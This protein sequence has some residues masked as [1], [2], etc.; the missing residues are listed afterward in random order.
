MTTVRWIVG[1]DEAGR[2]PLAGPVY[3][4]A[5]AMPV[6][7]G[8][9][10]LQG[11]GDSKQMSERKRL[12]VYAHLKTLEGVRCAVSFS[13]NTHID[14][15]GIVR[16]VESALT[17]ALSS[18]NINPKEA[19]ILLDGGLKAPEQ[20]PHQETH[21]RGDATKKVIGAASILAK[22]SRDAHMTRLAK[23]YPEYGFN[24]HKGYGTKKHIQAIQMNGL[25]PIHRVTFCK[26]I[27]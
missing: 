5:C 17:R 2:G 10:Q 12:G 18:L 27:V 8:E 26:N 20:Y 15:K 11:V 16:A 13:K 1:V 21:I 19:L 3:V 24:V 7:F 25:T 22:V 4:G 23:R 9:H 14:R 6:D